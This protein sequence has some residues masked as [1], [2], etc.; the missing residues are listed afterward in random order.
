[1]IMEI[2][3]K[4][5]TIKNI[6]GPLGVRGRNSDNKLIKEMIGWATD[7]PLRKGLERTYSWIEEEVVKLH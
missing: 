6:D 2:A 1:M 7:Y 5:L 3:G 4:R